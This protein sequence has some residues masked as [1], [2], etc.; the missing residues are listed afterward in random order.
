MNFGIA[1][2]LI[3]QV[4]INEIAWMGTQSSHSE[5]WI[6]LRN[7]TDSPINL[8]GWTLRATDGSPSA[9]LTKNDTINTFYLLKR[10]KNYTGA[11]ENSGEILE[12]YDS[13]GNLIDKVNAS[14]GWPAGDNASKQT[15]EKTDSGWQ[16]SQNP[17]GT[18]MSENIIKEEKA[19]KSPPMQAA[20]FSGPSERGPLYTILIAAALAFFSGG[21]IL[22]L[23]KKLV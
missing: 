9:N 14:S 1:I 12:L 5:E 18:P 21:I 20:V 10:G 23:K 15:M 2:F 13:S 3:A 4:A 22:F 7:N 8:A 11:L 17:G 19:E 16:T 6:E